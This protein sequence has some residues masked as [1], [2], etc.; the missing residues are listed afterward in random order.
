MEI[1]YISELTNQLVKM[2]ALALG[3]F[4]LTMALTPVYTFA[5]Y[6]YRFWKKPRTTSTTGERSR[7][8]SV[9]VSSA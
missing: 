9:L 4:L 3:G 5:A 1:I 6:R 7:V 2:F 8:S